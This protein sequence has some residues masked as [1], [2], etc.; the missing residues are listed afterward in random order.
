MCIKIYSLPTEVVKY[1]VTELSVWICH[2]SEYIKISKMA[3]FDEFSG[4]FINGTLHGWWW[5]FQYINIENVFVTTTHW[6]HV[7][8]S[9]FQWKIHALREM[10]KTVWNNFTSFVWNNISLLVFHVCSS[11]FEWL[12]WVCVCVFTVRVRGANKR[13]KRD[14]SGEFE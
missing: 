4:G 6:I 13:G 3:V 11:V 14:C 12:W 7:Q 8:T 1:K 2:H 5:L 9:V 10:W